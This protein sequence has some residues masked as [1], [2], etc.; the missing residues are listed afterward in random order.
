MII[1]NLGFLSPDD[2]FKRDSV[3]IEIYPHIDK[4]AWDK[5]SI[6]AK[7]RLDIKRDFLRTIFMENKEGGTL[8]LNNKHDSENV[9][10]RLTIF[11]QAIIDF[12]ELLGKK[13]NENESV[14]HNFLKENPFL[15]DFYG[16]PI[17]KP[18]FYYP[19]GES[20]L[21]KEYVEPDFIIKYPGNKY[22]LV[23]LERPSKPLETVK[24]HPRS[25]VTQS[26]FQISEWEDYIEKHYNL[27]K[28][29]FPSIVGNNSGMVIIRSTKENIKL[30]N[31]QYTAEILTYD[32]L[33]DKA[34]QAYIQL[35][36][37]K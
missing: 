31:K 5:R 18:K 12:E 1:D 28:D 2:I 7:V 19:E 6:W 17:S 22:K 33:L 27:I 30:L 23:E 11:A 24:G 9:D 13:I 35:I 20:P 3:Y 8:E 10:I 25:E 4:S 29:R 34:K 36:N 21:G 32:N 37:L 26:A 16:V 14:F 15:L